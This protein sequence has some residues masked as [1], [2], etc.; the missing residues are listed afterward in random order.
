MTHRLDEVR[1]SRPVAIAYLVMV[2]LLWLSHVVALVLGLTGDAAPVR[3]DD[4]LL[5]GLGLAVVGACFLVLAAVSRQLEPGTNLLTHPIRM[6]TLFYGS[7]APVAWRS[8]R[9]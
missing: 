2:S 9:D 1:L 6:V 7:E 8:L 5:A 4:P 3:S